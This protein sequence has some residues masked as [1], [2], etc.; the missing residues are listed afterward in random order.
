MK[1]P[2]HKFR[3]K[4]PERIDPDTA[5]LGVYPNGDP[6]QN[7]NSPLFM[8]QRLSAREMDDLL[9]KQQSGIPGYYSYVPDTDADYLFVWPAPDKDMHARLRFNPAAKEI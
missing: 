7:P 6:K 2:A 4:L 3:V 1:L 5:R 8:V 9:K